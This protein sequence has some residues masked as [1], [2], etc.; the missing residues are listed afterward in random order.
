MSY[1]STTPFSAAQSHAQ[2][3][4]P[5]SGTVLD[6]PLTRD[7]PST[8]QLSRQELEQLLYGDPL[9]AAYTA[10]ESGGTAL[11][12]ASDAYFEA[13]VNRLPQVQ[14]MLDQHEAL[15]ESIEQ[16][17]RRNAEVQPQLEALRRE[18]QAY[19]HEAQDLDAQ[20]AAL[21]ASLQEMY[22]VRHSSRIHRW[23]SIR[24]L[25]FLS[26]S[27]AF[28]PHHCMLS[29]HT[30]RLKSTMHPRHWPMLT[31]KDFHCLFP[32]TLPLALRAELAPTPMRNSFEHS[33]SSE[34]GT[35]VVPYWQNGGPKAP[36][37]GGTS[38]QIGSGANLQLHGQHPADRQPIRV[39]GPVLSLDTLPLLLRHAGFH[40]NPLRLKS[41]L[42]QIHLGDSRK[43]VVEEQICAGQSVDWSKANTHGLF[44]VR[45]SDDK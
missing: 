8:A 25:T 13:F 18:T 27:S 22:K 16:K 17:A 6:T 41:D 45:S 21:N 9:H 32:M 3:S 12:D 5:Q 11:S 43:D 30:A 29:S 20:W 28:L 10:A 44:Q 14:R 40:L 33:K 42:A 15:L 36:S 38:K 26:S 24:S 37:H 34:R 31:W 35:I 2:T 7:F 19:F 4:A 1:S 39:Q 23:S